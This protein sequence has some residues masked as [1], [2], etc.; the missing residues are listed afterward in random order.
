[1]GERPRTIEEV[2]EEL[3]RLLAQKG[4]PT[5]NSRIQEP[6]RQSSSIVR[7]AKIT[8]GGSPFG[9]NHHVNGRLKAR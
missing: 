2:K 8:V 9:E 6:A 4:V 3:S 5:G 1:M 7:G